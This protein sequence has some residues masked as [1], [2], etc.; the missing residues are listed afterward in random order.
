MDFHHLW[1]S[2]IPKSVDAI[3]QI[4]KLASFPCIID[5]ILSPEFIVCLSTTLCKIEE[6]NVVFLFN[7]F[8]TEPKQC[9]HL[10][11]ILSREWKLPEGMFLG[12]IL[13]IRQSLLSYLNWLLLGWLPCSKLFVQSL[14]LVLN[15]QFPGLAVSK[16]WCSA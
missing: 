7:Q 14:I 12:R 6:T 9:V 13:C 15:C 4:F 3:R 8:R 10:S 5:V 11:W 1:I 2:L 16:Y